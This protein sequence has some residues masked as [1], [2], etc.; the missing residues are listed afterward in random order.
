MKAASGGGVAAG[1]LALRGARRP[2]LPVKPRYVSL[3]AYVRTHPAARASEANARAVARMRRSRLLHVK[4]RPQ[5]RNIPHSYTLGRHASIIQVIL[6]F[7]V[8]IPLIMFNC[9]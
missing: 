6:V 9:H 4:T 5:V 1:C 8:N 3:C 7:P 2:P